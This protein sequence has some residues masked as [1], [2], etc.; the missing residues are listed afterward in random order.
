ML[1]RRAAEDILRVSGWVDVSKAARGRQLCGLL[2]EFGWQLWGAFTGRAVAI[3]KCRPVP[4]EIQPACC[5]QL[6]FLAAAAASGHPVVQRGKTPIVVGG[7]GFYL[8]WFILGKPTTP[9]ASPA[10][11]AAIAARMTPTRA[12]AANGGARRTRLPSYPPLAAN[13]EWATKEYT[14]EAAACCWCLHAD[15]FP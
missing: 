8:R 1:A 9:A 2:A 13:P 6:E 10:S 15:T 7:T 3:H 12:T 4:V 5:S 14:G 11:E